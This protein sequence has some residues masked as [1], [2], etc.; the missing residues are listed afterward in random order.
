MI[1]LASPVFVVGWEGSVDLLLA[2]V[3]DVEEVQRFRPGRE[4][5]LRC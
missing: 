3:R 5:W 4:I 2:A 1:S